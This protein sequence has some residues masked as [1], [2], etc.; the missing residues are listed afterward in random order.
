M[1]IKFTKKHPSGISEG[2]EL[3][4]LDAHGSRLIKEGF[5]KKVEVKVSK[6]KQKKEAKK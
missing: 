5:A 6:P 3:K 4:V 2:A 1:L